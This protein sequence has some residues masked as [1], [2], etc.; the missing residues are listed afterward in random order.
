VTRESSRIAP[1]ATIED[2]DLDNEPI[3]LPSGRVL[4][5]KAAAAYGEEVAAR[6]AARRRG[7]PSLTAPGVHS[8]KVSSR[9]PPDLRAAIDAIAERDGV[10]P[11]E[12]VRK[13]LEEY[14][15]THR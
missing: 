13:A 8:P 3:T 12:V 1:D 4:D 6:A 15:A 5:E 9:V 14:V 11:A 7:R 10:R 2:T